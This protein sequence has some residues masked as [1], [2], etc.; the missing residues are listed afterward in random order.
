MV[1][2]VFVAIELV[3][4][5]NGQLLTTYALKCLF[6]LLGRLLHNKG[7]NIG[8]VYGTAFPWELSLF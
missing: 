2:V 6:G 3:G 1:M 7:W 8:H 4:G 5:V